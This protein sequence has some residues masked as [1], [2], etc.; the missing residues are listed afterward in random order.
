MMMN[1][2]AGRK[3]R[4]MENDFAIPSLTFPDIPFLTFSP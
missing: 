1:M 3:A 4:K 2:M